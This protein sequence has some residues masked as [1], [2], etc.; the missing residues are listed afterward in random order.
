MNLYFLFIF[1]AIG[2]TTGFC[3]SWRQVTPGTMQAINQVLSVAIVQDD[4][5]ARLERDRIIGHLKRQRLDGALLVARVGAVAGL[6]FSGAAEAFIWI[7][8]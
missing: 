5:A 1:A 6:L 7:A 2:A 8:N 3:Y 4:Q